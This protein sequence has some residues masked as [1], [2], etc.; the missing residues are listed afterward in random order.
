MGENSNLLNFIEKMINNLLFFL[1]SGGGNSA[2]LADQFEAL[3]NNSSLCV[4]AAMSSYNK[5]PHIPQKIRRLKVPQIELMGL[6][7]HHNFMKHICQL[8]QYVK[9]NKI[10]IVHVQTNWELLIIGLCLIGIDNKAQVIYT[11][12]GFRNNECLIKKLVAKWLIIILLSIFSDYVI[13]SCNYIMNEFSIL[14]KKLKLINLGINDIFLEHKY[15]AVEDGL[16][17]IFPAAFRKGKRQEMIISALHEYQ[18]ITCDNKW[19]LILP[20]TGELLPKCKS[21]VKKMDL[22]S[23]VIFPGNLS[24]KELL[25]TYDKSNIMICSSISETYC[26]SIVEAYCLGKCVITTPVGIATELIKDGDNGYIYDEEKELILKLIGLH[27]NLKKLSQICRTNF[28]NKEKYGW[29]YITQEYVRFIDSI[30]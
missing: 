10:D 23:N 2:F 30:A 11:I 19:M 29:K 16:R 22:K 20:G 4:H 18:R 7:N 25:D 1:D 28:N 26:F 21:M 27:D 15:I 5:A 3:V 8:R 14:G 17:I 9:N 13:A 6:E 12:H 24:K